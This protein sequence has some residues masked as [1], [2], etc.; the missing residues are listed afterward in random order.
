M[1]YSLAGT[2]IRRPTTM[3]ENNNTQFAANRVLSGA[4]TRDYFG[5]NK[6]IWTLTYKTLNVNDYNTLYTIYQNFLLNKS[7]VP[8]VV[9]E[10][11]YPVPSM[12][13]Y[14]DFPDRDFSIPGSSYLSDNTLTLTEA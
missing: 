14:I 10:G 12:N 3:H 2:Q 13:V 4:N 6:R 9:T 7:P 8:L 11:N 5:D 1:S